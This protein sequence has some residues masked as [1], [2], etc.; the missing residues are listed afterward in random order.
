MK[1]GLVLSKVSNNCLRRPM[2]LSDI[3]DVNTK[4]L[5]AQEEI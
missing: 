2:Y 3:L 1:L 5:G 4:I